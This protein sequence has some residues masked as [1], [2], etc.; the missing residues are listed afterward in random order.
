MLFKKI[1]R[2]GWIWLSYV[3]M[4]LA[5]FVSYCFFIFPFNFTRVRGRENIPKKHKG[6][7]YVANHQTMFDPFFIGAAAFFP[8]V[9]TRPGRPF[10]NLAAEENY[11]KHWY[12]R[13]L[14]RLMRTEKVKE[15]R[16]DPFLLRNL[17]KFLKRN[18]ILIFYQRKRSNNLDEIAIG[19]AFAVL[20][21]ED[22]IDVIPVYHHGLQMIFSRGGP[23]TK[24]FWRWLPRNL[25]RRPTII[26]G[27]PID[28]ST[29][30][31]H[32]DVSR[33][34]KIARINQLIISAIKSLE[35]EYLLK[36]AT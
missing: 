5:V 18:N 6:V 24:G 8:S 26:F 15:G 30:L 10:I 28:C 9:F 2:R 21:A 31:A 3:V 17:R 36:Y 29:V 27:K 13:L 12:L 19:P 25:F 16:N 7:L 22:P 35:K 23:G 20:T 32:T 4:V 33:E 14:L 34:F 1:L 11:F